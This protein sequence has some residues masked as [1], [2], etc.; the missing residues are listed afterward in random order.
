MRSIK[1]W[2]RLSGVERSAYEYAWLP[3][4]APSGAA[5]ETRTLSTRALREAEVKPLGLWA[6]RTRVTLRGAPLLIQEVFLP[7]LSRRQP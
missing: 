6:R 3:T 4:E 7:F 1:P 2:M 5:P